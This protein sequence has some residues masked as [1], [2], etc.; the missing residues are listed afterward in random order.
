MSKRS[1]RKAEFD[2]HLQEI[3]SDYERRISALY[4]LYPEFVAVQNAD[5]AIPL[6]GNP[7]LSTSVRKVIAEHKSEQ[8]TVEAVAHWLRESFPAM[9]DADR[10][11]ISNTLGRLAKKNEIRLITEKG[12]R[13]AAY[14]VSK[15]VPS[16]S[17]SL[18]ELV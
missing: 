12:I 11:W 14:V 13:P 9:A 8:I 4:T 18:E 10:T 5:N 2:R 16:P 15:Q 6:G 17:V 7:S 1:E 3:K